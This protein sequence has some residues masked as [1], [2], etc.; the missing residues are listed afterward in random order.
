MIKTDQKR[1]MYFMEFIGIILCCFHQVLPCPNYWQCTT[2][3]VVYTVT[4]Y[5][6]SS[7]HARP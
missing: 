5:I 1:D 3:C 4:H 6:Y 7:A 2:V